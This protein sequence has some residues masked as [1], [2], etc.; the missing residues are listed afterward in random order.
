VWFSCMR[1]STRWFG[2]RGN[3]VICG[4]RSLLYDSGSGEGGAVCCWHI[5]PANICRALTSTNKH[6]IAFEI[7]TRAAGASVESRCDEVVAIERGMAHAR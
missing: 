4:L 5:S 3:R 2:I 6:T 7:E 1:N